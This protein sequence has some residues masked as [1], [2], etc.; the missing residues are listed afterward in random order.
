MLTSVFTRPKHWTLGIITLGALAILSVFGIW[1]QLIEKVVLES[2]YG[3]LNIEFAVTKEQMDQVLSTF[4]SHDVLS[5]EI[6]VDLL[7]FLLMPGWCFFFIGIHVLSSRALDFL[8]IQE[9]FRIKS[10]KFVLFPLYAGIID[11]I[12]NIL[13]LNILSNPFTY[14]GTLVQI[15]F[16]LVI[17]KFSLLFTSIYI[18]IHGAISS[19]IE[20]IRK[21]I[22][23]N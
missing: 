16:G 6:Q 3:V 9:G 20:V 7:D 5:L 11:S 19:F 2:G 10:Q 22:K 17:A 1:I 15:L 4:I 21:F 12:E 13:I 8:D 14:F 23:K 18:G